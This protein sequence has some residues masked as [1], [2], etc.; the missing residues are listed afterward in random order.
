MYETRS[1]V[2][3]MSNAPCQSVPFNENLLGIGQKGRHS[4]IWESNTNNIVTTVKTC[5]ISHV[6][7]CPI[8]AASHPLPS[9]AV[10]RMMWRTGK[11]TAKSRLGVIHSC[12][13]LIHS[14][15]PCILAIPAMKHATTNT[16]I[17]WLCMVM[18]LQMPMTM[19]EVHKS[20]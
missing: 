11:N 20:C 2:T 16:G 6:K 13:L 8:Q 12:M 7:W 18:M 1:I 15:V 14:K 4:T 9:I 10:R 5:I 17:E 19:A 3:Q